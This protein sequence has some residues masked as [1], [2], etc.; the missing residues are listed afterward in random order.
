MLDMSRVGE[1]ERD[2]GDE[3]VASAANG[4]HNASRGRR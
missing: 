2:D 4:L 3:A 1:S